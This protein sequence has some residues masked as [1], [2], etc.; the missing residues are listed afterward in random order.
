[1]DVLVLALAL[2]AQNDAT[3]PPWLDTNAIGAATFRRTHPEWDGRGVAIAVLDTGVD[4]GAPGMEK[5][6]TGAVKV[7]EARDFTSEAMIECEPPMV[8]K[9]EQGQQTWRAKGG[10]VLGVERLKGFVADTYVCLGFLDEGRFRNS[11]V[12][13]L[14]GNGRTDDRFAVLLYRGQD[15]GWKIAIDTDGDRELSD[16]TPIETYSRSFETITLKGH[17]PS[18]GVSPVRIAANVED[19]CERPR[20]I[21]LHIPTG[22]HGTH[23]AGI[24]AGH[25]LNGIDGYDGIAPGAVVLSLKIGDTGLS[26]GA[27]VTESMKKALEFAAKWGREHRMPVVANISYGIGSEIEGKADIDT[28]IDRF[29]EENPHVAIA[30]SGG[31]SGPG[32]ST[33]GSPAAA[34]HALTVGAAFTSEMASVLLGASSTRDRIF[35][36]SSRGGEVAKPDVVAPGIAASAV[37]T[38]ERNDLMRG[39]SMA[40]PQGAGA[41]ALILSATVASDPNAKWC[42]GMLK[43]AVMDTARP[44]PGYTQLDQGRGMID[45]PRAAELFKKMLRDEEA[46]ALMDIE[47]QTVSPTLPKGARAAFWRAGGYAPTEE[48]PVTIKLRPKFASNAPGSQRS[49]FWRSFLVSSNA[50]WIRLSNSSIRLKGDGETTFDFHVDQKAI[51]KPGVHVAAIKGNSGMLRFEIPVAVVVPEVVSYIDGVPGISRSKVRLEPGDLIR[52][53]VLPP[54]GTTFLVIEISPTKDSRAQAN[55]AVYDLQGRRIPA[56]DSTV[57]SEKGQKANIA[58][59]IHD[60]LVP[61]TLELVIQSP[62]NVRFVSELDVDV[63][64]FAMEAEPVRSM[65]FEAGQPPRFRVSAVNGT[66]QPFVGTVRGAIAGCERTYKKMLKSEP[67]KEAF[68]LSPEYEGVEF[69]LRMSPEDYTRFTDI[70]ITITDREGRALMKSGFDTRV[71]RLSFR[72]PDQGGGE[73]FLEIRGGWALSG[74]QSAEVE[75]R[76]RHVWKDRV[77]FVGTGPSGGQLVELYPA[78]PTTVEL[79][80]STTPRS[81]PA[82]YVWAGS[83]VFENKKDA[84]TWLRLPIEARP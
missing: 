68:K 49:S 23:V 38:W 28:F 67:L 57:S 75:I 71:A 66:A 72:N 55:V 79:K 1:M 43:R 46:W 64:F 73:F 18:R 84:R 69:E 9:D 48:R 13:D 30:V 6:T 33:I 56:P 17:D 61:G 24:A 52:M 60:V 51:K 2:T 27:S 42:S 44:L 19:S 82:G 16:E 70:A 77:S 53:P 31:N 25:R 22:S 78:V 11:S 3:F 12:P 4:M 76:M 74:N 21:E 41:M 47:V 65:T 36:F 58:F 35:L 59:S 29:A 81:C 54:S 32:L 14:N 63:R 20:A 39:T 45:V 8:E 62:P 5:T 7:V 83:V 34:L 80:A 40:A 37:P 50:S 26:G 15:G 10:F